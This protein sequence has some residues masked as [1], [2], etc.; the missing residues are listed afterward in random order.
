MMA[1]ATSL[2]TWRSS[3]E[4]GPRPSRRASALM[5]RSRRSPGITSRSLLTRQWPARRRTSAPGVN[6]RHRLV[7]R[8]RS[9]DVL[10][11]NG[12]RPTQ[13][14][15]CDVSS[16]A[17]FATA[18]R[19]L[20]SAPAGPAGPVSYPKFCD[21]RYVRICRATRPRKIPSQSCPT[22]V[23]PVAHSNLESRAS[24]VI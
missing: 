18:R 14:R 20:S 4:V 6:L 8:Y 23:G 21:S 22:V 13:F 24:L 11:A 2:P 10:G 16:E 5:S 7:G 12:S 15:Y 3:S 1:D 19:G 9:R 17:T